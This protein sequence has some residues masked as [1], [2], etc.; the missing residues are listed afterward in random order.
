MLGALLAIMLITG[1][2]VKYP[3]PAA[4]CPQIAMRVIRDHR[5]TTA[6]CEDPNSLRPTFSTV[7]M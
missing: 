2:T 1:E 3:V 4:Q 5:V 6:W 7:S